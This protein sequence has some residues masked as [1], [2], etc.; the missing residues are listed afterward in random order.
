LKDFLPRLKD[1]LLSRILG[2][3]YDGDETEFSSAERAQVLF[4]ND[5]IFQHKVIRVN[6]TTYDL[7]RSQDSL[8]PC[9][10]AD[11][12]VLGHEDNDTHPYWYAHILGVFH[13]NVIHRGGDAPPFEPRQMDFLWVWWFGCDPNNYR[14]GWK[15]KRLHRLGFIPADVAGAFGFL[16]PQQII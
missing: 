7:R 12:M 9:T 10:H 16:D 5:R 4:V 1:Y 8:N 2:H 13:A 11:V 3:E 15:A 14:S 6:Y